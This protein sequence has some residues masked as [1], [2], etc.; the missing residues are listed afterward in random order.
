MH[1]SKKAQ[2][3]LRAMIYLAKNEEKIISLRE[4]AKTEKIS[5]DFLE[6]IIKDLQTAG[7]VKAKKGA[8]GGYSLAKKP[9]DI[10]AGEIVEALEDIIPVK[11]AGCQMVRMCSSKSIWD[12]V[13]E[14][15]NDTL[16]SKTLKDLIK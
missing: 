14:S 16:Y 5:A 1:I 2:Y 11:C 3:G 8:F 12:E 9:K 15:L 13:K 10:Y 7:L 4:I 6:K